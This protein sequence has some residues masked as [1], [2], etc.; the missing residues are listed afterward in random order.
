M[1]NY[2]EQNHPKGAL[3][4]INF[5]RNLYCKEDAESERGIM[6][7]AINEML[8]QITAVLEQKQ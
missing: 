7:N 2:F 6:A 1:K 8:M 4:I 3:E 5:Y